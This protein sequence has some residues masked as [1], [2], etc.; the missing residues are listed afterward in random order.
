MN[1]C[2]NLRPLAKFPNTPPPTLSLRGCLKS[3]L[4]GIRY[5][6]PHPNPPL[7]K[8]RELDFPV[9]PPLYKLQCTHKLSNHY[10]SSNYPTLTLPVCIGEGTRFSCFPPFQG[11]IKGG[12]STCVY[13]VALYKGG[14]NAIKI[15]TSS[16][17]IVT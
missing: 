5:F 9:S 7:I 16:I 13:T 2:R 4:V 15:T 3:P 14:K 6:L 12:N 1:Q 10:Q 17:S 11:G 8:G